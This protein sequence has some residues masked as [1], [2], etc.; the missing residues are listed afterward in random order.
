M[1]NHFI[2]IASHFK[3]KFSILDDLFLSDNEEK[4]DLISSEKKINYS[5]IF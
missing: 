1:D 5:S 4:I 3:S 2:I